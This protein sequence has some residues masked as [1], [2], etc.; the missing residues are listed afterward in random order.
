MNACNIV[1]RPDAPPEVVEEAIR[2]YD[3]AQQPI[4]RI[5]VEERRLYV[6][7][8]FTQATIA[9]ADGFLAGYCEGVLAE[10][11]RIQ[12]TQA[13]NEAGPQA[14]GAATLFNRLVKKHFPE[15]EP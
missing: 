1:I 12:H 9:G 5:V 14:V 4:N 2:A 3:Q 6:E 13:V 15:E 8:V 11:K 10:R 7:R